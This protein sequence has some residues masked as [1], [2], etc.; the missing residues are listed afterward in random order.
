MTGLINLDKPAGISSAGALNRN[1]RLLPKGVKIGH[2]GTL[3]PFATGVLVVLIGK[4][5][6]LCEAMMDRPKGYTA[7]IKLGATT[8]T[9]DRDSAE[10]IEPGLAPLP[11]ADAAGI[12]RINAVLL[13]FVGQ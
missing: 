10:I 5:T 9:L 13:Q 11:P 7:T 4:A 12:A 2:A 3:D 6:R 1:K 8:E